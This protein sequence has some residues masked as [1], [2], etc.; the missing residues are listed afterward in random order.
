LLG[1]VTLK[2]SVPRRVAAL[3]RLARGRDEF[4]RCSRSAI[5]LLS[6][7]RPHHANAARADTARSRADTPRPHQVFSIHLLLTH[8]KLA[9]YNVENLFTRPIGPDQSAPAPSGEAIERQ[10]RLNTLFAKPAYSA[11]DKK[12]MLKLLDELGV[13]RDEDV[14]KFAFLRQ[15][16]GHFLARRRDG[17]VEIVADGRS[18]W[19]GSVELKF[20]D[21]NEVA[22]RGRI[23]RRAAAVATRVIN[24]LNADVIAL[25]EADSRPGLVRFSHALSATSGG[26][27]YEHITLADGGDER[28]IDVAL[29]TKAGYPVTA[30]SPSDRDA[31]ALGR[32]SAV[33]GVQTPKNNTV[34]L[35]V[36]HFK[37]REHGIRSVS[38]Q[39]RY[40]QACHA[41]KLYEMLNTEGHELIAVVGDLNETGDWAPLAPL[42][43]HT[44][45]RDISSHAAFE[46][47][48]RRR[49][50]ESAVATDKID[51]ILLSPALFAL[52]LRGA[53][54]RK[55][56][57]GSDTD[58]A[59]EYH[60]VHRKGAAAATDHAAI[61]AEIDV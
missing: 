33:Y 44:N 10:A 5:R 8:M 34:T 23:H 27:R 15:T 54:L 51:Y 40:H 13:L 16:G 45:L 41:K 12:S 18:S 3:M 6:R 53:V 17:S 42:L 37:S 55:S 60:E 56:A 48:D 47:G 59:F 29:M 20:P 61:W 7:L 25:A 35:L 4:A 39:K 22:Q 30:L 31:Q 9:C 50:D 46:S 52:T 58:R 36:N 26:T 24:E 49:A 43:R 21:V 1:F 14:G 28:G 19:Q 32:E 11:A 57:C 38:D 2:R